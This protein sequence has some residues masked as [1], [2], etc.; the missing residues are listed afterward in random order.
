MAQVYVRS[1]SSAI[2]PGRMKSDIGAG[3]LVSVRMMA[4]DRLTLDLVW[5][6]LELDPLSGVFCTACAGIKVNLLPFLMM[7]EIA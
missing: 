4:L 1:S 5:G 2:Y 3:A 6:H 7:T